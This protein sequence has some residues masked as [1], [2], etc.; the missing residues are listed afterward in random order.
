MR[1]L[2]NV[3]AVT[4]LSVAMLFAQ[5]TPAA[6]SKV[7][8]QT[9]ATVTLIPSS[10][11]EMDENERIRRRAAVT[12]NQADQ[13]EESIEG[14]QNPELFL[15]FELYDF[16]LWGLSDDVEL[17]KSAHAKYDSQIRE[18]GFDVDSF[19]RVV[20]VKAEPYI[21]LRK[22]RNAQ[23]SYTTLITAGD[24][25]V[26]VPVDRDV[27]GARISALEA[28]RQAFGGRRFDRLLY[29]VIAP[30]MRHSSTGK[31]SSDLAM[32]LR[33]QAGGCK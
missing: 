16:L 25:K 19:W 11:W 17:H 29:T 5:P 12:P 26:L 20:S 9:G 22:T 28:T 6:D 14:R 23:R 3:V 21:R 1:R 10:I 24:H 4:V 27:C 15:R 18:L 31:P 2:Q 8:K 33:F 32:K 30:R 13:R 7:P